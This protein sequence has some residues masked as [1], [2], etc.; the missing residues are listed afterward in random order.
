MPTPLETYL[1][2]LAAPSYLNSAFA[3]GTDNIHSDLLK[4]GIAGFKL[5][6]PQ[7]LAGYLLAINRQWSQDLNDQWV[8]RM[9]NNI[10]MKAVHVY[11]EAVYAA[12]QVSRRAGV[13]SVNAFTAAFRGNATSSTLKEIKKIIASGF[14]NVESC[15]DGYVM[16]T[17]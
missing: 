10:N 9:I 7:T 12:V 2:G 16:L 5:A 17:R 8:D 13:V 14:V 15:K 6:M 4:R 3:I 11:H 1:S